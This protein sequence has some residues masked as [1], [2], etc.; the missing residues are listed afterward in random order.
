MVLDK[1]RPLAW[2]LCDVAHCN[3]YRYLILYRCI[4][5]LFIDSLPPSPLPPPPSAS[6]SSFED[7]SLCAFYIIFSCAPLKPDYAISPVRVSSSLYVSVQAIMSSK[8]S[9]LY[10]IRLMRYL[11]PPAR[12]MPSFPRSLARAFRAINS[13]SFYPRGCDPLH[14]ALYRPPRDRARRFPG[15][16]SPRA[17]PSRS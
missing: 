3:S 10:A 14:L 17:F 11:H 4:S 8:Y 5:V 15:R 12:L 7:S 1:T 6:A 2:A 13:A 9:T 16:A